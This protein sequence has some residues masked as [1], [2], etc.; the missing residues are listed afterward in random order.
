MKTGL[1][2][3]SFYL[4]VMPTS[5]AGSTHKPNV[6]LFLVDDMGW[7]DLGVYGSDFYETPNIDA[8]AD[9]GVRFTDAYAAS[10]VC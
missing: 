7:S 3:I 10:H 6:I 2:L 4:S 8:L 9:K 5:F 1:L